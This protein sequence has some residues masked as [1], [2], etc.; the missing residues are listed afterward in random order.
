MDVKFGLVVI[1]VGY[2]MMIWLKNLSFFGESIC[3]RIMRYLIQEM[4]G[5][6]SL[7]MEI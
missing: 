4:H 6:M 1:L 3:I 2:W 7:S 5:W